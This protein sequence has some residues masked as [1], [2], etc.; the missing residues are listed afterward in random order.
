MRGIS[1]RLIALRRDEGGQSL[2]FGVMSIFIVLFFGAMVMGV[3]RVTARRVQMQF[4]FAET[5]E[6][7]AVTVAECAGSMEEL[8]ES[9]WRRAIEIWARCLKNDEWPGPADGVVRLEAPG[10]ALAR[11]LEEEIAA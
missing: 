4:V 5:K 6:P 1:D 2:V 7:Y 11:E 9:R 8:G 10:W 3:G